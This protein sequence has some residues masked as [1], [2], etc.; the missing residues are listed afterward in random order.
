MKTIEYINKPEQLDDLCQRIENAP[1]IAVDTEFL[2]E[3]R[4]IQNSVCCN[5]RPLNG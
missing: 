1:W 2:R 4:I 5:W 3:K